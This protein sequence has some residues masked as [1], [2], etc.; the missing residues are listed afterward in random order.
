MDSIARRYAPMNRGDNPGFP[1]QI[2]CID[3]KNYLPKFID[4]NKH[5]AI[6]NL[7]KIHWHI[8][9]LGIRFHE[10]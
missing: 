5:E 8:D 2:P 4:V 10:D 1:N 9:K 6:L 7:V 3:W